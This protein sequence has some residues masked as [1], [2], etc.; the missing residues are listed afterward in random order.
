MPDQNLRIPGPTPI[1][2]QVAAALGQQMINHRGPEFAEILRRVTVNLQHF[3]QTSETVLCFPAAGTGGQEAAIVNSFSPG[4]EVLAVS[5]GVFGNRLAKI[6]EI[7]GLSVTRLEVEWGQAA[8][9]TH[10]ATALAGLP[11]SKGVLITH[12][13][14]STGVTNDLK[15][16]ARAIRQERHDALI[17]VDAVSSLSCVDL[18]MDAWDLDVVIT[19]SQKGWMVPPGMT[20]IG[21]SQRAWAAVERA[22][23]P[24]FYWDFRAARK[25]LEKGQTPYTP[26]VSLFYGLDVALGMMRE[27]GMSAIFARHQRLGALTRE[28]ATELGLALFAD[29]AHAS[30]TVTALRVPDGV[31]AKA[32]IKA[33]REQD[34]VVI[35]GGQERLDGVI[36]RIGHMGFAHEAEIEACMASLGRQLAAAGHVAAR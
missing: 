32:V 28:R 34:G 3:F 15:T 10:V 29:P 35:S 4:D 24:R 9:A 20:M 1:P 14:T 21:V 19:G 6:A 27:E 26:A 36:F 7:Y 13:E 18:P 12:N 16:I 31:E 17:I 30:N 22:T 23:L 5:I 25:S 33:M 11:G 8:T 2:P